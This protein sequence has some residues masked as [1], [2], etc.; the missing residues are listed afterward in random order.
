MSGFEAYVLVWSHLP[1]SPLP[2]LHSPCSLAPWPA[3]ITPQLPS[4]PCYSCPRKPWSLPCHLFCSL[5]LSCTIA[6]VH[7]LSAF[8][9]RG[10]H[11]LGGG[12][13]FRHCR[14]G[15]LACRKE[16][17]LFSPLWVT[18]SL[19][20]DCQKEQPRTSASGGT[21]EGPYLPC[22]CHLFTREQNIN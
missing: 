15:L 19:S 17:L 22:K 16:T 20:S 10:H 11:P 3:R 12:G 14:L 18:A 5:R 9:C 6:S 2:Q 21:S 13:G 4:N 1:L 8:Q 7:V